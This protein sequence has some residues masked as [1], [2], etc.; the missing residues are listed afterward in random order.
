M[1]TPEI[2]QLAQTVWDY[3]HLHHPL[4]K[5]GAILV[6]GSN[7]TRVAEWAAQLWL[8]GWAPLLILSGGLG[9][10]TKEAWTQSEASLFADIAKQ[11]GVPAE[12]ILIE[13]RSTNTGENILFTKQ[14]L[15]EKGISIHKFLL[16]QK[17]LHGTEKLCH[18]L[19][20]MAW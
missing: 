11:K 9:R 18:L 5:S 12:A 8:D 10:L 16:V 4:Q 14:L 1:I 17:T 19:K 6:L 7:D 15:E 20:T 3:H 13:D 2:I